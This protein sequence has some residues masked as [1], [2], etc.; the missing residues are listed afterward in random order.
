MQHGTDVSLP[1]GDDVFPT[2]HCS[3][4]FLHYTTHPP[5][6]H[7]ILSPTP[8]TLSH[9]T[10]HI[11]LHYTTQWLQHHTLCPSLHNTPSCTTRYTP[12]IVKDPVWDLSSLGLSTRMTRPFGTLCSSYCD[13]SPWYFCVQKLI[14]ETFWYQCV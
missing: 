6:L 9:T 2:L 8:H 12:I 10:Q 13:N 3:L 4:G 11:L 7:Y 5:A 1:R 14:D